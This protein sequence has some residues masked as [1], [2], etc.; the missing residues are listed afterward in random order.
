MTAFTVDEVPFGAVYIV[1]DADDG[2]QR[3]GLPCDEDY[4][5]ESSR[6]GRVMFVGGARQPD[7]PTR[8]DESE[9]KI[10]CFD[11]EK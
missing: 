2:N 10:W 1:D 8:G 6:E 4:V 5:E 9:K 3:E 7:D 11:R